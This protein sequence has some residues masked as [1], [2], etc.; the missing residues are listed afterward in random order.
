MV[1][2][3]PSD[4]APHEA[5][6]SAQ[7]RGVQVGEPQ[8]FEVP[9]PPQTEGIVQSPQSNVPPQPSAM[10]PQLAPTAPQVVRVQLLPH[11]LGLPPPPQLSGAVQ[12]PH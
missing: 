11:T 12:A 9:P 3:Q 4:T 7:E 2:P 8:I 1:A 10:V 6:A 5:A